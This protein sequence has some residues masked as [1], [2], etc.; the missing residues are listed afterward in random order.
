MVEVVAAAEVAAVEIAAV[1]AAAIGRFLPFSS[2]SRT[3][4][5]NN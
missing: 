2:S 4:Y 5:G 3:F 1:M